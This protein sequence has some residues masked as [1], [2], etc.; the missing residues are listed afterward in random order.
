MPVKS[1]LFKSQQHENAQSSSMCYSFYLKVQSQHDSNPP[2]HPWAM[3]RITE[4]GSEMESISAFYR[5]L[6][7]TKT[8]ALDIHG[9][10]NEFRWWL[11]AHNDTLIIRGACYHR[12]RANP[13]CGNLTLSAGTQLK[14]QRW[15][16]SLKDVA[17]TRASWK[18]GQVVAAE[19]L[20]RKSFDAPDGRWRRPGTKLWQRWWWQRSRCGKGS[21]RSF[22]RVLN[23]RQRRVE[24][25]SV[26]CLVL[27]SRES[28]ASVMRKMSRV[29]DLEERDGVTASPGCWEKIQLWRWLSAK[30]GN[31]REKLAFGV[32]GLYLCTNYSHSYS[33]MH[34][35]FHGV[36]SWSYLI[37]IIDLCRS[38]SLDNPLLK[39]GNLIHVQLKVISGY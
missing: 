35:I 17:R 9:Q 16:S 20:E 29:R 10:D 15:R 8:N 21:T 12:H 11:W 39:S 7:P 4:C 31:N 22:S 32:R 6:K 37:V 5:T 23:E 25:D 24:K 33:E 19:S 28:A 1:R 14:E 38:P 26:S 2:S 18:G 13:A 27:T 36:G 3:T 30:Q 34:F